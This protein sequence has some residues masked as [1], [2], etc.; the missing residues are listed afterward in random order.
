MDTGAPP[1]PPPGIHL[2][3]H[4]CPRPGVGLGSPT[5]VLGRDLGTVA[6]GDLS[7][8]LPPSAIFP[9]GLLS[10]WLSFFICGAIMQEEGRWVARGCGI[11]TS[12]PLLV[13]HESM[14]DFVARQASDFASGEF[15]GEGG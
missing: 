5:A 13:M 2:C 10:Q 1:T 4:S 14:F 9:S 12:V 3:Q 7:F 6:A 15:E 11:T 8:L